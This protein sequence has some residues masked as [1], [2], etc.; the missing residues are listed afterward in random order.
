MKKR[1]LIALLA[2]AAASL[3]VAGGQASADPDSN[4]SSS[5]LTSPALSAL[6]TNDDLFATADLAVLLN[7][8]G[9]SGTKHYGPTRARHQTQGPVATSGRTIRSTGTS[10]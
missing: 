1:S 6:I 5:G 4:T 7:P 9:T 3:A 2:L 8:A 10:P